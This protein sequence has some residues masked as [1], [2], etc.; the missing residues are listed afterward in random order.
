MRTL[1][2]SL[3]CLAV[4][5]SLGSFVTQPVKRLCN[6]YNFSIQKNRE[7][8]MTNS[9]YVFSKSFSIDGRGGDRKKIEYT[10]VCSKNTSYQ[11]LIVSRSRNFFNG[12]TSDIIATIY[13]AKR[14][15]IASS[16]TKEKNINTLYLTNPTTGIYYITFTF[17]KDSPS[18][19][20]GAILS[21]KK[22]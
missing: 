10:Y 21:F 3:L 5:I 4:F 15:V 22:E 7:R 1:I 9:S 13:D 2:L 19:C 18:H 17:T 20:G 8:F 11:L 12:E 14:N 6:S 16:A